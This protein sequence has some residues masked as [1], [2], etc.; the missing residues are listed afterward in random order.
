[1]EGKNVQV[2]DN[3]QVVT[4]TDACSV[5]LNGVN[6]I[7]GVDDGMI[8]LDTVNGKIR[9]EGTDLKVESLERIGGVINARGNIKAVYIQGAIK[10]KKGAFGKIFG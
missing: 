6:D 4:I 2:K 3:K 10:E 8:L 9:I 5:T 7:I 1:M